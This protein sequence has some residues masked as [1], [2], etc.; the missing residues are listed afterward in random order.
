MAILRR[1]LAHHWRK[2]N[3]SFEGCISALCLL[4][5]ILFDSFHK[6]SYEHDHTCAPKCNVSSALSD[7]K[8]LYHPAASIHHFSYSQ[9]WEAHCLW[10]WAYGCWNCPS[11]SSKWSESG[12]SHCFRASRGWPVVAGD[13]CRCNGQGPWVSVSF[14]PLKGPTDDPATWRNGVNIISKSLA[15]VAKK[16]SPDDIEGFTNNVLKNISTTTD[17]WVHDDASWIINW[18]PAV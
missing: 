16:K 2:D 3:E 9:S 18:W 6:V 15:R 8:T 5:K 7:F 10:C 4:G 17:S 14:Q 1:V 13:T 11:W 12:Y